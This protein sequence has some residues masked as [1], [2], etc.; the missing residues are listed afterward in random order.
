[1]RLPRQCARSEAAP[2]A[3]GQRRAGGVRA[4]VHAGGVAAVRAGGGARR[5]R[6]ASLSSKSQTCAQAAASLAAVRGRADGC[7]HRHARS[8]TRSSTRALAAARLRRCALM[9]ARRRALVAR[10]CLF[11]FILQIYK[12]NPRESFQISNR[13]SFL[14]NLN[15]EASNIQK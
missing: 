2:D 14:A 6:W 3:R 11:L 12:N 13:L 4:V 5:L 9:A 10:G 15:F 8:A 7:V 1:M